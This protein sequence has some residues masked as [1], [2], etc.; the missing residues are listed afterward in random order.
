MSKHYGQILERAIRRNGNSI[1]DVA[2]LLNINRRS[3]YNWF[4]QAQLRPE[5]IY[6]IGH[7]INYDFSVDLPHL[8]TPEDFIRKP[9]LAVNKQGELMEDTNNSNT[10]QQKYIDLLEK[11]NALLSEIVISD[12]ITKN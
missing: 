4:N 5:I 7:V 2:R 10:W 3:V 1:S 8:F 9:R 12:Q 6:K 11:Y